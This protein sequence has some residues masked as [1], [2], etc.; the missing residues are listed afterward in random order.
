MD[1]IA[2]KLHEKFELNFFLF[3]KQELSCSLYKK[4]Y[5]F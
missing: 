3:F 1:N 4:T 5:K 2:S